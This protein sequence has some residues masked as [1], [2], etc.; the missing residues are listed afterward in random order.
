MIIKY[1]SPQDQTGLA[2]DQRFRHSS[3]FEKW[4]QLVNAGHKVRFRLGSVPKMRLA[5]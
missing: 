4:G 1:S 5:V 3:V 2:L